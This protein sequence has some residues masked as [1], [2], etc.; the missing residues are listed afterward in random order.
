ME[1]ENLEKGIKEIQNIQMTALEKENMLKS[2]LNNTVPITK[3][4]PIKSPY[5]FISMF[6][7]PVFYYAVLFIMV[8][9]ISGSGIYFKNQKNINPNNLAYI[10][11]YNNSINPENIGQK[12]SINNIQPQ[13][14]SPSEGN[15]NKYNGK[16][17]G[18][19]DKKNTT[20]NT[21]PPTISAPINSG[22]NNQNNTV[23][24]LMFSTPNNNQEYKNIASNTFKEWLE[25]EARNKAPF[26]DCKINEIKIIAFKKNASAQDLTRFYGDNTENAFTVSVDYTIQTSPENML[27]WMDENSVSMNGWIYNLHLFAIVD[28]DKNGNYYMEKVLDKNHIPR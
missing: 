14:N 5:S 13:E 19:L 10:P 24:M 9:G 6:R 11:N 26:L 12:I 22:I 3:T 23:S 20:T 28:K 25:N 18:Y 15:T 7:S 17:I 4:R 16:I 2:I 1:N 8:A 27:P 21:T